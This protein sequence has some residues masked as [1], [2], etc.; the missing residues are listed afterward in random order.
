[1]LQ[2]LQSQ[3]LEKMPSSPMVFF[4]LLA[5]FCHTKITHILR[6]Q[7]HFSQNLHFFC[8]IYRLCNCHITITLRK[9]LNTPLLNLW[10]S[11]SYIVDFIRK[12]ITLSHQRFS[13]FFICR[14]RYIKSLSIGHLSD[15]KPLRRAAL[16]PHDRRW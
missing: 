11:G 16:S 3:S 9:I 2:F 15:K 14:C 12:D 4:C 10:K 8:K 6:R 1:M 7:L 5:L 13:I